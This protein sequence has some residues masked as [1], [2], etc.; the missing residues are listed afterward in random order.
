MTDVFMNFGKKLFDD[1]EKQDVKES[2][3]GCY[4][5]KYDG[6][7]DNPCKDCRRSYEDRYEVEE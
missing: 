6:K 2:G 3:Y 1:M 7:K 5:C 4:G